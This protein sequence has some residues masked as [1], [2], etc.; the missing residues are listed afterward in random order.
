[1]PPD[2]TSGRVA[3]ALATRAAIAA[4]R[5]GRAIAFTFERSQPSPQPGEC[6]ARI[7][8]I[9]TGQR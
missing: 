4:H 3:V 6:K 7:T 8:Y 2:R 9:R 5:A 1:M